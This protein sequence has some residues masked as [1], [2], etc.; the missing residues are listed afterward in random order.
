MKCGKIGNL[1]I[2]LSLK[3]TINKPA[4]ATI[5]DLFILLGPFEDKKYDPER[6][7]EL[8]KVYKRRELL[9]TE[10]IEKAQIFGMCESW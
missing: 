1:E 5:E 3:N 6:I 7:E 10:K 2:E 4:K 9:E 8:Y